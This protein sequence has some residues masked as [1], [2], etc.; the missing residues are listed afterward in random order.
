MST[1]YQKAWRFVRV[2]STMRINK[3]DE[4]VFMYL[5]SFAADIARSNY[6]TKVKCRT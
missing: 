3:Y 6:E 5:S 4:R 2:L 1:P